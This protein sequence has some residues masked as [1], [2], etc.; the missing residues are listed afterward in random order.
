MANRSMRQYS[1]RPL[2]HPEFVRHPA[3]LNA[4][5]TRR[6]P[7]T[8]IGIQGIQFIAGRSII[9]C[10]G[11]AGSYR[12]VTASERCPADG[13][14]SQSVNRTTRADARNSTIGMNA[15]V[16]VDSRELPIELTNVRGSYP[17]TRPAARMLCRMRSKWP[18]PHV[19][20]KNEQKRA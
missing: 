15:V 16:V 8:A 2:D 12:T 10:D 5:M 14:P 13:D 11:F 1:P 9:A 17:T 7:V 3:V 19:K 18:R 20:G 6:R 4:A